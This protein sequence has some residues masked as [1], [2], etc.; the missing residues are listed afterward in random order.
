MSV[1][2]LFNYFKNLNRG[3]EAPTLAH[4]SDLANAVEK[5]FEAAA[6]LQFPRW[7]QTEGCGNLTNE[8]RV[9]PNLQ[10]CTATKVLLRR[11]L[12]LDIAALGQMPSLCIHTPSKE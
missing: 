6:S 3:L 10:F 1:T 4:S 5:A 9:G 12:H 11:S 2:N 7:L 8:G